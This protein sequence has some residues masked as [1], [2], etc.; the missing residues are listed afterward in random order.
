MQRKEL[1]KAIAEVTAAVETSGVLTVLR[2][3]PSEK[4][5]RPETAKSLSVLRDYSIRA[6]QYTTT[7]RALVNILKL[8]PLEDPEVWVQLLGSPSQAQIHLSRAASMLRSE[9]GGFNLEARRR[10]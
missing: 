9:L 5:G 3:D 6:A 10:Q 4:A 1:V 8:E 2:A 7:A